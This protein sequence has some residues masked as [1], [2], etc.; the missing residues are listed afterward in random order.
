VARYTLRRLLLMI[1]TLFG[2]ML[3]NFMIVQA[4]PGGPIDQM[5]ARFEGANAMASSCRDMRTSPC[6]MDESLPLTRHHIKQARKRARNYCFHRRKVNAFS[7][8]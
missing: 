6:S 4:A 2:I 1:P 8:L 7:P 3:L 5:L